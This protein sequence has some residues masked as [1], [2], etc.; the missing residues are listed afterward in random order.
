MR[1]QLVHNRAVCLSVSVNAR[2]IRVPVNQNVGKF[3]E[4]FRFKNPIHVQ[5]VNTGSKILCMLL[6]NETQQGCRIILE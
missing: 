1:F 2:V 4:N 6:P 3:K 5:F